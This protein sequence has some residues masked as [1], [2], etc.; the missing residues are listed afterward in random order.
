M[1]LAETLK[2]IPPPEDLVFGKV[3]E[4]AHYRAADMSDCRSAYERPHDG[5]FISP[6]NGLVRPRDQA[7]RTIHV[8]SCKLMLP[9]LDEPFRGYESASRLYKLSN[10]IWLS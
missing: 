5:L 10:V 7:L 9:I 1:T 6:C 3:R 2:E 8:G 4:I